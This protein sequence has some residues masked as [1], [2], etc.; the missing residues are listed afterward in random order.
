MKSN[1]IRKIPQVANVSEADIK[2]AIDSSYIKT[3]AKGD[4]IIR[5]EDFCCENQN[6]SDPLSTQ[7]DTYAYVVV[8]GSAV[9]EKRISVS[10]E[11]LPGGTT[12]VKLPESS[13]ENKTLDA[14]AQRVRARTTMDLPFEGLLTLPPP[15]PEFPTLKYLSVQTYVTGDVFLPF[16]REKDYVVGAKEATTILFVPKTPFLLHKSGEVMDKLFDKLLNSKICVD[17]ELKEYNS[18]RIWKDYRKQLVRQVL[19]DKLLRK[20]RS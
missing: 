18:R 4:L 12:I 13:V 3:F 8:S 17:E 20:S 9:L 16:I 15:P 19:V 5:G 6:A 10:Q 7:L 14:V 1:V 2:K 11:P